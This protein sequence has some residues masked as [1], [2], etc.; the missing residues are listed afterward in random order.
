MAILVGSAAISLLSCYM[1]FFLTCF[2]TVTVADQ[3]DGAPI[4]SNPLNFMHGLPGY[5]VM[6]GFLLS[7][8]SL[9]GYR[10]WLGARTKKVLSKTVP[11][12]S[13]LGVAVN[14][15]TEEGSVEQPGDRGVSPGSERRANG[16]GG[17]TAEGILLSG[18]KGGS[19]GSSER[20]R[21]VKSV[22]LASCERTSQPSESTAESAR[23]ELPRL[24][25]QVSLASC[26]TPLASRLSSLVL[27]WPHTSPLTPRPSPLATCP[28]PPAV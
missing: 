13:S 27:L 26:L 17:V 25:N 2:A 6:I 9:I 5:A 8:T 18:S 7:T 12:D 22:E 20:T 3:Y 16:E 11:T 15:G 10:C 21:D 19:N 24:T 1:S 23:D 4:Y 14:D 28:S